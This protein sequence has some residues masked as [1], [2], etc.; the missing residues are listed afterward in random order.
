MFHAISGNTDAND[1]RTVIAIGA[2]I[3]AASV[4]GLLAIIGIVTGG[5]PRATPATIGQTVADAIPAGVTG[6][7]GTTLLSAAGQ[8]CGI[9]QVGSDAVGQTAHGQYCVVDITVTNTGR[10]PT[11]LMIAAQG[12]TD[13]T[14]A[15]RTPDQVASIYA[16][17][18]PDRISTWA[19]A[20]PA[21]AIAAGPIAF[22]LPAGVHL[23]NVD[24]HATLGTPGVTVTL[25]APR[26]K[27]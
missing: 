23:V 3:T 21:G 25:P 16:A 14:C 10:Y 13:T 12:A 20:I 2:I 15:H 26:D 24:L 9:P 19:R 18:G 17:V 1:R 4:A 8:Q 5:H 27:Q 22:D 11:V 6:R 7:D